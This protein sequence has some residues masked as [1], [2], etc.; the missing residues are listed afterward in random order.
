MKRNDVST[1]ISRTNVN[2]NGC[3]V[4]TGT[5]LPRGYGQFSDIT[6]RRS[7]MLAYRYA[8]LKFIGSIPGGMEVLHKCDNPS[9]VNPEHL[10]CGSQSDNLRDAALKKR[11]WNSAKETCKRG[12]L[13][14][15]RNTRIQVRIGADGKPVNARR[16]LECHRTERQRAAQQ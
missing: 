1:F 8:Y 3:W 4:W 12:H 10:F 16:C 6:V 11:H 13:F 15:D 2:S 5:K 9:C 7:P 14:T